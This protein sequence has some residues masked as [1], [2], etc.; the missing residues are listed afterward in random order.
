M[1]SGRRHLVKANID[2]QQGLFEA[3]EEGGGRTLGPG[4][5]QLNGALQHLDRRLAGHV[6]RVV[7]AHAVR[8]DEKAIQ[9]EGPEAEGEKGV[10]VPGSLLTRVA[11]GTMANPHLV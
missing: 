2:G 7:P 6:S 11:V 4:T 1:P 9:P 3:V 5:S 10:F 8:D